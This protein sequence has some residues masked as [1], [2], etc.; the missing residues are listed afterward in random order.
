VT[1]LLFAQKEDS[2]KAADLKTG[3][4]IM[5]TI[6]EVLFSSFLL[7]QEYTFLSQRLNSSND[8]FFRRRE[9]IPGG[10]VKD[11]IPVSLEVRD[12]NRI[13]YLLRTYRSC[14]LF[15]HIDLV[16]YYSLLR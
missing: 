8:A 5:L 7:E 9:V 2:A 16:M 11:F 15:L 13:A 14:I 4:N 10:K 1:E 12:G 3:Y 6:E